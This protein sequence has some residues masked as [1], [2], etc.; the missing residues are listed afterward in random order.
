MAYVKIPH[1]FFDIEELKLIEAK[2][3][4]DEV[5]CFLLKLILKSEPSTEGSR[6]Y[7]IRNIEIT[8]RVLSVLFHHDE[9]M[10]HYAMYI[11]KELNIVN[12][13]PNKITINQFW[14]GNRDRNTPE[15][16]NWRITVFERD[17]YKCTKCGTHKDIQA[18]HIISWADTNDRRHLRFDQENGITLCRSC[19]L[20]EHG[21]SWR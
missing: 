2:N 7:S 9:S 14:K 21:G 10:I 4:S 5:I 15:Y 13:E 19:H 20:D 18:H 16:K 11:F 1:N 8:G 6:E 3:R 12:W 17:G